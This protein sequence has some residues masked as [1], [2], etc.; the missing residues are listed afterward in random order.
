MHSITPR[1]QVEVIMEENTFDVALQSL[2][3]VISDGVI[4]MSRDGLIVRKG[5]RLIPL[6]T[7]P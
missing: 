1:T 6:S 4:L 3:E 5:Y 2:L 7:R